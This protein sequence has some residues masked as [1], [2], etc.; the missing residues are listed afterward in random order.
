MSVGSLLADSTEWDFVRERTVTEANEET[1]T[2]STR[3]ESIDLGSR[4]LT[5]RIISE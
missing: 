3:T 5:D 2:A 1:H 4:S